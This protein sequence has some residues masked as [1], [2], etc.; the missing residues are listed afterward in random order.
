MA[1]TA[2]RT[3]GPTA[4]PV[5]L[6]ATLRLPI[7]LARSSVSSNDAGGG[8]R[9][10]D[11]VVVCGAGPADS[12]WRTFST[13]AFARSISRWKGE[14]LVANATWP[15]WMAHFQ[16]RQALWPRVA[17]RRY[18]SASRKS[19]TARRSRRISRWR[20]RRQSCVC[21]RNARHRPVNLF[22][23]VAPMCPRRIPWLARGRPR[24]GVIASSRGQQPAN[25]ST[26]ASASVSS[27]RISIPMRPSGRSCLSSSWVR[28]VSTKC[29]SR[30]AFTFGMM[31]TSRFRPAAPT[32]STSSSWHHFVWTPLM[33]TARVFRP[34]SSVLRPSM[35]GLRAASFSDGATASSRSRKT[36]SASLAAAFAII[37]SLVPGVESS[38]RRRRN[39]RDMGVSY[40]VEG[41]GASSA[42]VGVT[43][44]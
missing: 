27:M 17:S 19:A 3:V 39:G 42:L 21:A 18:P 28:S 13:T 41:L 29:T 8:G 10:H 31:T 4:A 2:R 22:S 20:G 9:R 33:R 1:G 23:V 44:W 25:S 15:G 12:A 6:P 43:V 24:R 34:Q 14:D 36:R 38:E 5:R 7:N 11:P 32:I 26:R 30:G 37:F 40:G 35:I 16:P